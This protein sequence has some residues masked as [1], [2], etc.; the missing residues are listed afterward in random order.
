MQILCGKC[1]R[2]SRADDNLAGSA[3]ACPHCGHEIVIPSIDTPQAPRDSRRDGQDDEGFAG[4]AKREMS[5]RLVVTCGFCGKNLRASRRTMGKKVR[6][7]S[8]GKKIH[9]P[10][11]Q[12]EELPD[13][14][15]TRAVGVNLQIADLEAD[16]EEALSVVELPTAELIR[17]GLP[18]WFWLAL[19]AVLAGIAG[20]IIWAMAT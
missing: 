14:I 17:P 12:E 5:R 19:A 6:C 7:P 13:G 16:L 11:P 15:G 10:M 4:R 1:G 2:T 8:C 9:V 20:A 18:I 3:V